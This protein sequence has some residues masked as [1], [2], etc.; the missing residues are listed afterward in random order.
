PHPQETF[1]PG[2]YQS[3]A[4]ECQANDMRR[5]VNPEAI[6]LFQRIHIPQC[7]ESFTPQ[8]KARRIIFSDS[9][10]FA[11]RRKRQ[12]GYGWLRH[13]K[14]VDFLIAFQIPEI[15]KSVI[16]AGSKHLSIG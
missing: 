3:F 14:M 2:S 6:N 9:K 16:R 12:T 10:L 1:F 5:M 11:I 8:K 15:D 7:S 13:L 4:I